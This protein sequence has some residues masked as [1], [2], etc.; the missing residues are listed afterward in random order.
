MVRCRWLSVAAEKFVVRSSRNAGIFETEFC[1]EVPDT[2]GFT[3]L[4]TRLRVRSPC[5]PKCHPTIR[6]RRR[7]ISR[8]A[9]ANS[10]HFGFAARH[11][12]H[13]R[14]W[15]YFIGLSTLKPRSRSPILGP[16]YFSEAALD[17]LSKASGVEGPTFRGVVGNFVLCVFGSGDL[18]EPGPCQIAA[19]FWDSNI[20]SKVTAE[21]LIVELRSHLKLPF[22][23]FVL[24]S[25]NLP[26]LKLYPRR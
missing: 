20:F 8:I 24:T 11:I 10:V 9:V 17:A 2:V 1:E 25:L 22:F 7:T 19:K 21:C 6:A 26:M 5:H 18:T 13:S 14:Y 15:G 4:E 23:S 16:G 12:V 3:L